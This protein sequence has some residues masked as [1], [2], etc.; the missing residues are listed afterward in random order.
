VGYAFGMAVL[1]VLTVLSEI[2]ALRLGIEVALQRHRKRMFAFLG[3]A[4]SV[5][6]LA[7]INSQAVLVDL[8]KLIVAF[9][10]LP[11]KDPRLIAR[12][13]VVALPAVL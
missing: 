5:L 12:E 4:C 10:Q 9:T 11:T 6:V 3:V 7:M 1:A 13:R 2:A 8:A